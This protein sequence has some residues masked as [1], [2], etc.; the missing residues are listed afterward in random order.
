MI[1]IIESGI[2]STK[3]CRGTRV[4]VIIGPNGTAILNYTE[5]G[6]KKHYHIDKTTLLEADYGTSFTVVPQP[7]L[8]FIPDKIPSAKG[9]KIQS[10]NPVKIECTFKPSGVVTTSQTTSLKPPTILG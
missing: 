8:G 3:G 10:M 9:Y 5:F 6:V 7:A 4:D 1:R 2:F